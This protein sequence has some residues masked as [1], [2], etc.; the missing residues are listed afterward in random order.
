MSAPKRSDIRLGSAE[1]LAESGMTVEQE[2]DALHALGQQ[3]AERNILLVVID[4]PRH[5]VSV[6]D[7][8]AKLKRELYGEGG[9]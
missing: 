1:R 3:M 4:D 7:R 9:K 5:T 2:R 6:T 8:A